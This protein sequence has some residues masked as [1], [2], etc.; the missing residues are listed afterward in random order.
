MLIIN[1][2]HSPAWYKIKRTKNLLSRNLDYFFKCRFISTTMPNTLQNT[3]VFEVHENWHLIQFYLF[4]LVSSWAIYSPSFLVALSEKI[5]SRDLYNPSQLSYPM[6]FRREHS[7]PS[8]YISMWKNFPKDHSRPHPTIAS[9]E[10]T[11]KPLP[12]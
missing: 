2:K 11:Q 10:Q 3:I 8:S 5:G 6:R 9:D 4:L 1:N 7:T 12:I